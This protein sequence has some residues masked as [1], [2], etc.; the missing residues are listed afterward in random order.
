MNKFIKKMKSFN[1]WIVA[2]KKRWIIGIVVILL[3]IFGIWK[4]VSSSS[5][6]ITYQTETI[7]KG[8]LV[9]T[10]SVSGKLITSN[11]LEI[12]TTATGV[13]KKVYVKDGQTVY[14]GQKIAEITLDSS[15]MLAN[16]KAKASL[17]STNNNYRS[18][19]AS[20]AKTYEEIDGH[21][22][23][24]T[25]TMKETRTKAEVANDNAWSNLA[26]AQL[27]YNLSSPI[28]V[29]PYSGVI[30]NLNIVEGINISVEKRIATVSTKGNPVVELS[31]SEV[32]V[33]KV[34]VGQKA[35]VNFDSLSDKSFTGIVVTVDKVGLITSNVT[36]YT[37]YIRLD[38]SSEELL[39]NMS[40]TANIILDSV[41]DVLIIPTA[42]IQTNNNINYA[43]ILKDGKQE[44]VEITLGLSTDNGVEVRSGLKIGEIVITGTNTTKQ[45]TTTTT[46]SVFSS[47]GGGG[48]GIPR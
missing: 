7:E 38:N 43:K 29:S 28:V 16:A 11:I 22:T 20:L 9:S 33:N 30:S 40:G 17:E 37:A 26:Q 10:V 1:K 42:A 21:D 32:D 5:N 36:N 27:T 3:A 47:V 18:S 41:T 24:E 13:V 4:T 14:K 48:M 2:D 45:S 15:G 6:K 44:L 39:S 31:L 12:K 46:K 35:T 34:K 8:T 23:D 25:L 19:Q